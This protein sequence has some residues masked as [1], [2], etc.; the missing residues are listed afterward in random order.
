MIRESRFYLLA[1]FLT[2]GVNFLTLPLFTQHL[3]PSDYGVIGLF[4][5]F[6]NLVTNLCAFGL[7]TATYGIFFRTSIEDFKILNFTILVFLSSIFTAIGFFFIFPFAEN[8]ASSIFSNELDHNL[9][10][11]SF[12]NGCISYFYIFYGQLL[13]AQEK[14]FAFSILSIIQV[15]TNASITFYFIFW[16]ALTFMAAVY[17]LL[18]SNFIVLFIA[19]VISRNLFFFNFSVKDLKHALRFGTPEVPNT[20]VNLLY[21]SFDKLMIVNSKGLSEVGYYDFGNR[22]AAI[23]KIFIDAI[24]K[25]FS[26]YFLKKAAS[27]SDNKNDEIVEKFFEILVILGFIGVVVALFSEEAL[28]ILT[29]EDFYLAKYLVPLLVIFYLFGALSHISMNQFIYSQALYYLAPISFI[30]LLINLV[31]NILLIPKYGAFGAV[32][33]TSFAA[34]I[35]S[36]L[37]LYFGNKAFPLPVNYKNLMILLFIIIFFVMLSYPIIYIDENYIMKFFLKLMILP[38]YIY[39]VIKFKFIN[40]HSFKENFILLK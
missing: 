5:V 27:E 39:I 34:M 3:S 16:Q 26:P 29:T 7:N 6:G 15:V 31:A 17:G 12:I 22:F 36:F 18:I 20:M 32:I 8:I 24:G 30:G 38:L 28:I 37:Q 33:A 40:P 1:S 14:S 19:L 13:V 11:L 10:K 21:G 9:I 23:L 4:L 2:I 35:V 25:S